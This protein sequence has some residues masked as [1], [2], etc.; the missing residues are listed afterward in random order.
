[1]NGKPKTAGLL[2]THP[3]AK[4]VFLALALTRLCIVRFMFASTLIK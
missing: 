4:R 3:G 2:I 1:M